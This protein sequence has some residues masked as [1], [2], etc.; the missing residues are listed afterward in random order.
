MINEERGPVAD[1]RMDPLLER[2]VELLREPE[3]VRA[4][5]R[6]SL[7]ERV[8]RR[9]HRRARMWTWT[10]VGIAA[11]LCV[12]VGLRWRGARH[13]EREVRFAIAA[14]SARTVSL[15]GDFDRWNP[16]AV[17]MH[18]DADGRWVVDVQLPP[19]RHVYAYSVDGGLRDDPG[20]PRAVEDDFGV[21]S[22]VI[23]VS[24]QG[25]E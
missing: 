10:A 23:V 21:P 12:A 17:P 25:G 14:P 5:W 24:E 15:V 2:A 19:G 16:S 20:A 8:D 4:E 1:E 13:A 3:P 11:A 7:L 22:S 18:R 9:E 6:A